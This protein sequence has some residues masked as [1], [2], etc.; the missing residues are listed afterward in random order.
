MRQEHGKHDWSW[1]K[2]EIITNWANN[3]WGFKME[4]A[5]EIL[6]FNSE[7]DKPLTWFLKPKDRLSALHPVM[8]DSM[9]NM[10]ILREC[11]GELEHAIK[12][13]CLE[14]CS[15]EDYINAMEDFITRKRLGKTWIR[16]PIES[17]MIPKIS[18]EDR[19]PVFK[20]HKCG[21]TSH[22]T[23]NC[24]EK[25]KGNEIQVIEEFQT[26]EEKEES[27]EHSAV[28]DNTPVEDYSIE[29]ITAFF[30]VTELH[31]HFPQYSED[32]YNLI[33]IQDARICKTKPPR[34]KGC[35]SA[36]SCITSILMNDVEAKINLD[37]EA[38]CTCIGKD[39]LQ[40][41]LP[42]WKNHQLPIEG[43]QFISAIIICTLLEY[44]TL[45]F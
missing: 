23:N 15:I 39:Y 43:V 9:I 36:A 33:N 12:C 24:V 42:E 32:C 34:V 10:K 45:I 7:K 8:S 13:R 25:T 16:N 3:S 38:F 2:S 35:T 4:N 22:L 30:E 40:I 1:W 37:T 20:C 14:P 44:W 21:S 29:N 28:S 31:T 6:I 5:C 18:R 26:A 27:D 41:I 11:G 17:K 19:K